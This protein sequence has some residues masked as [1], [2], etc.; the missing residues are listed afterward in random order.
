MPVASPVLSL[1]DKC[2]AIDGVIRAIASLE[3]N[4]VTNAGLG[5]NLNLNGCVECDASL[6]DGQSLNW[7]A[8]GALH[9]I[10]N[11]IKAAECVLTGQTRQQPCGLIAP[12]F[13]VGEGARSYALSNGCVASELLTE[14]S[15]QSY[16][17]YK[18]LLDSETS[19]ESLNAKH[20]R[21]DTVGAI[22]VDWAGNVAAGASSGGIH[23][24]PS[25]R[26]G[27]A[28]M[29]GCGVWAQNCIAVT[30]TGTGEYLTKTMFAK[31]CAN[32]LLNTSDGNNLNA[33][34]KAFRYGFTD[35]PLLQSIARENRL[36]GVLALYHDKDSTHTELLWGHSTHSMCIGYMG[37]HSKPKA[38]ISQLPTDSKPGLYFKVE[39]IN[40]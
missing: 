26:I 19:D 2:S 7:G 38:F 6:M 20:K 23:L 31:E 5:S 36:G 34:N 33:L 21:L 14:R 18:R 3:D 37:S 22:C 28:S 16:N 30:T 13:L 8:V 1:N 12:N 15:Q 4:D 11:P 40:D 39:A 17:R 35:S 27:Q 29:M 32:H 10:K 25:G 24:K 9:G